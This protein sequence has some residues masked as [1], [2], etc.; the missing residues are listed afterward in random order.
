MRAFNTCELC[1]KFTEYDDILYDENNFLC[2]TNIS[3]ILSLG[4]YS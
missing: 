4:V 3:L 2:S 1:Y